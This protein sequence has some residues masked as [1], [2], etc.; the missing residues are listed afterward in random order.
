MDWL[1]FLRSERSRK[2]E[3]IEMLSS[4]RIAISRTEGGNRVDLSEEMIADHKRHIQEI[5]QILAN[6]EVAPAH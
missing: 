5:E 2:L 1:E 6:N 3:S 4:G